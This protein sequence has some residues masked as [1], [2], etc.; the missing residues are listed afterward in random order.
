MLPND[1]RIYDHVP[2]RV[3]ATFLQNVDR[4]RSV[5]TRFWAS[6]GTLAAPSLCSGRSRGRSSPRT[7]RSAVARQLC[8]HP[9]TPE[10]VRVA[11]RE[12]GGCQSGSNPR[13]NQLPF[14]LRDAREDAKDKPAIRRGDLQ[15]AFKNLVYFERR[16]RR[17]NWRRINRQRPRWQQGFL[18]GPDALNAPS[19]HYSLTSLRFAATSA[20]G[21]ILAEFG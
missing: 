7:P 18:K 3:L 5:V 19:Q 6:P 10:A 1:S 13:A 11:F 14:K 15:E 2:H 8:E 20:R 4:G 17:R 12:L 9:R 21:A 16:M